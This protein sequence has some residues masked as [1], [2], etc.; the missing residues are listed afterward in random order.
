MHSVF[1]YCHLFNTKKFPG[2]GLFWIQEMAVE[3]IFYCVSKCYVF[4]LWPIFC[5]HLKT[6]FAKVQ[7][8]VCHKNSF[9]DIRPS[10]NVCLSVRYNLVKE[11]ERIYQIMSYQKKLGSQ[12]YGLSVTMP[13]GFYIMRKIPSD[14][15]HFFLFKR[16]LIFLFK[17]DY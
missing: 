11:Q 2:L 9:S 10:Q 15:K 5:F 8:H 17:K 6:K 4:E 3:L 1:V 12:N 7:N 16:H 13:A 14:E